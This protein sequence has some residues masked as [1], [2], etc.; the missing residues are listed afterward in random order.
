MADFMDFCEETF[1]WHF[2]EGREKKAALKVTSYNISENRNLF[3][4]L[5]GKRV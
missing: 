3:H 2:L 4:R 1:M 5:N